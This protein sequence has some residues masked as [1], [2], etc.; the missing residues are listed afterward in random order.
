[1]QVLL[2]GKAALDLT[3]PADLRPLVYRLRLDGAALPRREGLT[4]ELRAEGD[5]ALSYTLAATGTQRLDEVGPTGT[6]LRVR[7]SFE[8]IDGKPLRGPV[9]VGDVIAVRLTVEAEAAQEYV[10]LEERRP[11]G[12]EFAAERVEAGEA[13]VAHV[14]FRD[15]R[16][17]VFLTRLAAGRTEVVYYLRAETPGLSHVLPGCVYPMYNDKVRGET[18]ADKVEVQPT[19]GR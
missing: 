5:A 14:E 15:D 19:P 10:L 4:V 11:A 7:R 12:C 18:G 6:A 13:A 16:L 9:R 1:V 8:T 3:D 2:D 17:C